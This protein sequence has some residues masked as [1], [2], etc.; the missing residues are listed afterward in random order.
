MVFEVKSS[1]FALEH[2][3]VGENHI[4]PHHWNALFDVNNINLKI[5]KILIW[6]INFAKNILSYKFSQL[7]LYLLKLLIYTCKSSNSIL[8]L[9][10]Y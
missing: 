6:H 2:F 3:L 8:D 1:L 10:L 5:K 7:K 9:N 4:D